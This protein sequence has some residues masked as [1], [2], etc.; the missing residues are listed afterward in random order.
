[1][2]GGR[3]MA[4]FVVWVA[5]TATGIVLGFRDAFRGSSSTEIEEQKT[6][7]RQ[8]AQ[9]RLEAFQV[10]ILY[11]NDEEVDAAWSRLIE[12]C[13]EQDVSLRVD[14]MIEKHYT[15]PHLA[16]FYNS[17]LVSISDLGW[18]GATVTDNRSIV[19]SDKMDKPRRV[20]VLAHE[21]AH[22]I[23]PHICSSRWK[24]NP[25][26]RA[27]SEIV[28]ELAAYLYSDWYRINTIQRSWR[29][30]E[31]WVSRMLANGDRT[32]LEQL[33]QKEDIVFRVCEVLHHMFPDSNCPSDEEIKNRVFNTF[34]DFSVQPYFSHTSNDR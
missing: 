4:R 27:D 2:T 18:E 29:Y 32:S 30:V 24:Q 7:A 20:V 11:E 33:R 15:A 10:P 12:V 31:G 6:R 1:M 28:A 3:L 9:W 25:G 21:T 8:L 17:A 19:I 16:P 13:D 14:G 23:D 26:V 34:Y 22:I 5:A